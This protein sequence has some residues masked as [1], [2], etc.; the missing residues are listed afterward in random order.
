MRDFITDEKVFE[1]LRV[2]SNIKCW[3][4][5]CELKKNVENGIDQAVTHKIGGCTSQYALDRLRK[6]EKL[7]LVDRVITEG[8]QT[9]IIDGEEKDLG[10]PRRV[11]WKIT[12]KGSKLVEIVS[13]AI[14]Q[15]FEEYLKEINKEQ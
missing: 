15:I 3:K 6:L 5:L 2:I 1:L 12:G 10:A 14:S 7:N 11:K 8:K 13:E 4:I 9:K